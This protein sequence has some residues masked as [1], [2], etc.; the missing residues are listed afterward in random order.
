MKVWFL[1]MAED[2]AINYFLIATGFEKNLGAVK[3]HA[4][5][6]NFP[7]IELNVYP[8]IRDIYVKKSA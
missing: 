4:A 2:E 1:H 7:D 5:S 3:S 6:E 8:I